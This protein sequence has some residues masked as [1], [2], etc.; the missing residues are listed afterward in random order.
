LTQPTSLGD[1]TTLAPAGTE[2]PQ[3]TQQ[4]SPQSVC[5]GANATFSVTATGGTLTYQWQTNGVNLSDSGHYSGATTPTLTVFNADSADTANYRCVVT[6]SGGSTNSATAALTLKAATI[7]NADPSDQEV[8]AGANA[9]LGVTATGE[10]VLAYQWQTN[11][12]DLSDNSHYG[13]AT[14]ATLTV[15]NVTS[16]DSADYRCVVIGGCGS[17]NS[18]AAALTVVTSGL[19]LGTLNAAFE[20][21]F[22]LAGGGYIADNWIEWEADPDV[23][24]G[25]DETAITHG[26]GHAQ[27][28]RV[29][30]GAS[31]TAGGVYQRVPVTVGQAYS[32][33][34]WTYAGDNLTTCSLGVDPTGGIDGTGVIWSAGSTN[35]AWVQQTVA[36]VAT[37]FYITIYLKVA[38]PDDAKRNGYF[39]DVTPGSSSGSFQL[40]AQHDGND[41][42][43]IWPECPNAHLECTDSLSQPVT[44]NTVTNEATVNGGLKSVTI[45][46]TG[47]AGY[48]RLVLD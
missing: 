33:S 40:M 32:V 28:I 35:T 44:W 24:I 15:F 2:S 21:G 43:L 48:Y 25:Y 27:R 6:N 31:G 4:P 38:T 34:V 39:D 42:I 37:G 23:V 36:G 1:G 8:P 45:A 30:G 22:S 9:T 41:L 13:G 17:A 3:I 26:G 29:W 18:A 47:E 14:S 16:A 12:V 7:I 11:G 10:G 46:P 5:P 20:D 19:C